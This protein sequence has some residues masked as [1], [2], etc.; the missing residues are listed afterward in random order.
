M[1]HSPLF[2][3][4]FLATRLPRASRG[5]SFTMLALSPE[6]S[7]V[8]GPLLFTVD[9]PPCGRRPATQPPLLGLGCSTRTAFHASVRLCPE[10]YGS[11]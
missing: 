7:E 9:G 2:L 10:K 1:G 8:E 5:H 3:F 6:G 11:S 4:R